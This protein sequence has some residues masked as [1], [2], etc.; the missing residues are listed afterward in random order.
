MRRVFLD[1]KPHIKEYYKIRKMHSEILS[2]MVQYYH[3]GKFEKQMDTNFIPETEPQETVTIH[4]LESSFDLDTKVGAQA[5]YDIWIYKTAS[6]AT[7]IA[8]DFIQKHRYRKP[9][10]IEFLH[11]MLNSN[12]GLFEVTGTDMKEVYAHLKDVLTGDEYTIVD[13][14]LSSNMADNSDIYI[15]TRIISHNGINFSSGLNFLFKKTDSFIKNHI[16]QHKKDFNPNGEF[17]RFTQLYNHY[18]Q[19][20]NR[21]R[22]VTNEL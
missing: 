9:E 13:L 3:D 11:S 19:D 8:E 16:Q 1:K 18:S 14:G 2:A 4:L 5:F 22:A 6:N 7:C 20:S 12:L 21:I 15:Y 10:K 17:Q